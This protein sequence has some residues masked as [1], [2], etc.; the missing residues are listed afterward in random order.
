MTVR[1][2]PHWNSATPWQYGGFAGTWATYSVVRSEILG[3]TVS[4][5]SVYSTSVATFARDGDAGTQWHSTNT[6]VNPWI[7]LD[8]GTAQN[9]SQMSIQQRAETVH[10]FKDVLIEYSV[11]NTVWIPIHRLR[12]DAPAALTIHTVDF[13]PITARYWRLRMTGLNS[14]ADWYFV[15]QE[16]RLYGGVP[17]S[18]FVRSTDPMVAL[19]IPRMSWIGVLD[20]TKV[21]FRGEYRTNQV[22]TLGGYFASNAGDKHP[23]VADS[24]WHTFQCASLVDGDRAL[25]WSEDAAFGWI[26]FRN[27]VVDTQSMPM[28]WDG[29]KWQFVPETW[30]GTKWRSDAEGWDGTKWAK[31][32]ESRTDPGGET[33]SPWMEVKS[34][35]ATGPAPIAA[36]AVN[37]AQYPSPWASARWRFSSTGRV[38]VYG[39]IR[40]TAAQSPVVT[41]L[42]NFTLPANVGF[43][44]RGFSSI[45]MSNCL[46]SHAP[47]SLSHVAM[48]RVDLV[49]LSATTFVLYMVPNGSASNIVNGDWIS[50]N[51]R[52]DITQGDHT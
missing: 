22:G 35:G 13:E 20:K 42:I 24:Q 32:W 51:V 7:M 39:L 15:V 31:L 45:A 12:V 11:D 38:E 41:N 36:F 10:W 17:V 26:E 28:G 16:W 47:I 23:T 8:L 1:A 9:V 27:V 18:R 50:L 2:F 19:A 6:S 25:L 40:A 37:W 5:S 14:T 33:W 52:V 34:Y 44:P 48:M 4:A 3:G 21:F 29:N 30:D 46:T 43:A 49:T